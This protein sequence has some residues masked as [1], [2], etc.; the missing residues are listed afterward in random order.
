M[1]D[2]RP[3]HR[4]IVELFLLKDTDAGFFDFEENAFL[5]PVI[6]DAAD[7]IGFSIDNS[8]EGDRV[9]TALY[10]ALLPIARCRK[11]NSPSE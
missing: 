5:D 11:N 7:V 3:Y 1:A 4:A 6:E 9:P 2:Y 8:V 10:Q